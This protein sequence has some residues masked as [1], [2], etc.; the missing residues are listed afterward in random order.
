[1]T[2]ALPT[3]IMFLG[4][5]NFAQWP[6]L[7]EEEQTRARLEGLVLGAY[8]V[9]LIGGLLWQGLPG[10]LGGWA[11]AAALKYGIGTAVYWRASGIDPAYRNVAMATGAVAAVDLF[12]AAH[13]L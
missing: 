9:G 2:T 13:L 11:A 1:M 12:L 6:E 3:G 5:Q 4:V 10:M 7:V 8:G